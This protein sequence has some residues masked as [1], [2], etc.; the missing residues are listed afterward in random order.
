[1]DF[2][3]LEATWRGLHFLCTHNENT[4]L[5]RIRIFDCKKNEFAIELDCPPEVEQ[6]ILYQRI[7]NDPWQR[8][9]V[10]PFS[11]LI[12][13]YQFSHHPADVTL[14]THMATLGAAACCPFLAAASPDLLGLERWS[15]LN[16]P[17][18]L[19]RT[20]ESSSYAAWNRFRDTEDARYIVL[21][22]P[23]TLA[24]LP[25]TGYR[26]DNAGFQFN[27]LAFDFEES[28]PEF[29]TRLCWMNTAFVLGTQMTNAFRQFGMCLYLSANVAHEDR[30]SQHQNG[31]GR[32]GGLPSFVALAGIADQQAIGP[33]EFSI[34]DRREVEFRD[35]GLVA[36][37]P[38]RYGAAFLSM[39][40]CCRSKQ[41]DCADASAKA[42]IA[43]D[44]A[45][46]MVESRF[47]HYVKAV[48]GTLQKIQKEDI[49]HEA[50]SMWISGYVDSCGPANDR[51]R[52]EFP[53]ADA[54]IDIQN[55]PGLRGAR[56]AVMYLRPWLD[57]GF[58][59]NALRKVVPL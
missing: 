39:P 58:P 47:A 25:F 12:A 36:L 5:V 56:L 26:R 21:T 19:T 32:I 55:D 18:D 13:D 3:K 23:R 41:H 35:C 27:E 59:T 10:E 49:A 37:S 40:T 34:D 30:D 28:I 53:L 22:G 45:Y 33:S 48:Y 4:A 8:D 15:D 52:A 57:H 20:M 50:L 44:L 2:L 24:R 43:M 9:L 51:T 17:H 7:V 38:I 29:N 11:V 1:P 42:S 16:K 14:L 31:D 46:V 54:R 6:S